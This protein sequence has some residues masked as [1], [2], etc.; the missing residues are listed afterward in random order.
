MEDILRR[1]LAGREVWAFG[2]R[3]GGAAGKH[4]DLDLAVRG[5][6]PLD[7]GLLGEVRDAFSDSDLPFKVDVVYWAAAEEGFR[8]IIRKNFVVV[9]SG[10]ADAVRR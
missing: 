8:E 4:S 1:H 6:E 7:F 3:A 5:D 2:S 9:Q 10:A